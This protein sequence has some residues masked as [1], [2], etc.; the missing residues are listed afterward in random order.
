M[1]GLLR[2]AAIPV[3]MAVGVA[4]LAA[5]A[6][7]SVMR[8]APVKAPANVCPK[9]PAQLAGRHVRAPFSGR[10]A[11]LCAN[12]RGAVLDDLELIQFDMRYA[13]LTDASLVH[14]SLIQA[15]L[16]GAK[17]GRAKF[18]GADLTQAT[19]DGADATDA[20]FKDAKL[21]QATIHS[22]TLNGADLTGADLIQADLTGT[23]LSGAT[24]SDSDFG[25]AT[26]TGVKRVG[27]H[28]RPKNGAGGDAFSAAERSGAPVLVILV[29]VIVCIVL[30]IG[31]ISRA[32][33]RATRPSYVPTV[34]DT[35]VWQPTS[36]SA[37][38]EEAQRVIEDVGSRRWFRRR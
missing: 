16:T 6:Q 7:A 15:D 22:A 31:L 34:P 13:D 35:P 12:L 26:M 20:S 25:Q 4:V 19:L 37:S 21:G 38:M 17:L 2:W 33:R 27:T 24:L 18:D 8:H 3:L 1:R 14:T 29:V 9:R 23:D 28:G 36:T 5:P 32:T 10:E 11:L 30:T